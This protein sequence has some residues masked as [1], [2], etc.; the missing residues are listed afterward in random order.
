M[1]A[2]LAVAGIA[3][4]CEPRGEGVEVVEPWVRATARPGASAEGRAAP[5]NGAAYLVVR[6]HGTVDDAIVGVE[7]A[8]ADTAELHLV[9]VE[10]EIMRMRAVE[11]V[12]VP[13]GGEAV[14][15]PGGYH[16]MLV[17]LERDLTAGDTVEMTVRLRSGESVDVRAGVRR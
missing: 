7:T 12:P 3:V 11:S 14:L 17:G 8:I 13:A 2:A 16:V 1:V 15:E 6:N 4:G 9:T 10:N 5:A